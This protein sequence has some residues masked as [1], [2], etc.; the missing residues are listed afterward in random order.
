MRPPFYMLEGC[1]FCATLTLSMT[2]MQ[3]IPQHESLS[4]HPVARCPNKPRKPFEHRMRVAKQ[5]HA[6]TAQSLNSL[7]ALFS[8]LSRNK[9]IMQGFVERIPGVTTLV[10]D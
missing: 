1:G 10:K 4:N 6:D 5:S 9:M 7:P 3:L 8:F 2:L